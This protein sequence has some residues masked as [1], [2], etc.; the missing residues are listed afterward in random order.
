MAGVELTGGESVRRR[1]ARE[2][3]GALPGALPGASPRAWRIS[4]KGFGFY[5]ERTGAPW[6]GRSGRDTV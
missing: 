1:E 5:Y 2:M 4:G 3:P 6:C